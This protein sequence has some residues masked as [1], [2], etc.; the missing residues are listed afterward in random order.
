MEGILSSLEE[1]RVFALEENR[2]TGAF[3]FKWGVAT[4]LAS[5]AATVLISPQWIL[6]I[7]IP[8]AIAAACMRSINERKSEV[9]CLFKDEAIPLLLKEKLPGFSYS[10]EGCIDE[11]EFSGC[12]L[13]ISPDSYCGKDCFCGTRGRTSLRFSMVH[14]E[15]EY[16]ETVYSTDSDGNDTSYT[17]TCWRDIFRG[18]FF[19]ADFNKDFLHNTVVSAGRPGL[20]SFLSSDRVKLEDPRFNDRFTVRSG[21]QI[22]ARYILTPRLME[23]IVS[24]NDSMGGVEISFWNSSVYIAA[25][26]IPYNAFTPDIDRPFS[27]PEQLKDIMAWIRLVLDIVDE[28]DLNTRI[29]SKR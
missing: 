2:R 22:E 9:L 5:I 19:V 10:R 3:M 24:L 25:G 7:V 18:L 26:S 11:D 28:L 12:G 1:Q 20:F 15:E 27:D 4:T 13:F 21:D 23:R 17:Q 8:V 6:S 14:A 16:E 29:W